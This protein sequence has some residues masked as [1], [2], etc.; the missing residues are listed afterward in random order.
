MNK[1]WIPEPS[2][3][4]AGERGTEWTVGRRLWATVQHVVTWLRE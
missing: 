2:V 1:D 3:R 4:K